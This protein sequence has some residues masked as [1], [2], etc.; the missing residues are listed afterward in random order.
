MLSISIDFQH[1]KA[2]LCA[3]A[4]NLCIYEWQLFGPN[5]CLYDMHAQQAVMAA[6]E[7]LVCRFTSNCNTNRGYQVKA[8]TFPQRA[9][10]R[11]RTKTGCCCPCW[12]QRLTS[13]SDDSRTTASTTH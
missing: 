12:W 9:H 2:D 5:H 4:T 13:A 6:D 11:T 8:P 7:D 10:A 1:A 3:G